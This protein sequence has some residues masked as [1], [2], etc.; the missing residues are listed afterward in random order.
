M[1]FLNFNTTSAIIVGGVVPSGPSWHSPD[2]YSDSGNKWSDEPKA[3]DGNTGT[4]AYVAQNLNMWCDWC[5]FTFSSPVVNASLL[6]IWMSHE[7]GATPNMCH[8]KAYNGVGGEETLI[9]TNI[10]HDKY[11]EVAVTLASIAYIEVRFQGQTGVT[12]N[13]YLNEVALY[14]L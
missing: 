1:A 3:Y 11:V 12:N 9:Y 7:V 4:Y 13:I 6:R 5:R 2:G 8:L 10:D 14:G